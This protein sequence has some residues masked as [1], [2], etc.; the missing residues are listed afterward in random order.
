VRRC[1]EDEPGGFAVGRVIVFPSEVIVVH[2]RNARRGDINLVRFFAAIGH[3]FPSLFP[4]RCVQSA[5]IAHGLSD[6]LFRGCFPAHSSQSE[7]GRLQQRPR[8]AAMWQRCCIPAG[9]Q[10]RSQANRLCWT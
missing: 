6:L 1:P 9:G 2:A 10:A 3:G 4:D 5:A 7:I 8:A